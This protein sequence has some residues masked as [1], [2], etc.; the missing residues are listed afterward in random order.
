MSH[1][2]RL[3]K[4]VYVF[5]TGMWC[6]AWGKRL[7]V[8]PACGCFCG[9]GAARVT[10][11]RSAASKPQ[12]VDHSPAPHHPLE[13]TSWAPVQK[14]SRTVR[15]IPFAFCGV[16]R[17]WVV[18]PRTRHS[19]S[20]NATRWRV[21]PSGGLEAASLNARGRVDPQRVVLKLLLPQR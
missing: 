10:R 16:R 5:C 12:G 20:L 11:G 9:R 14:E 19:A 18:S 15:P 21:D 3:H 7:F 17:R 1:N 2:V 13:P 4:Y 8:C 6:C